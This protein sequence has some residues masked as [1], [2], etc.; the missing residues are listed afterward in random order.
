MGLVMVLLMEL[1]KKTALIDR[2][3]YLQVLL[4]H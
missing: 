1:R 4:I 2:L 3:L